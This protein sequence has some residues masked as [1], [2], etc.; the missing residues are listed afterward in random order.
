[1]VHDM[2]GITKGFRP[3]F[4]RQYADLHTTMT[5]AIGHYVEDVRSGNFP[6]EQ[7]QY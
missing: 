1:M 6:N 5:E 3:K 2:L 7:E 4:L